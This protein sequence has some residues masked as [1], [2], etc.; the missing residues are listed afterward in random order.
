[1]IALAGAF[2]AGVVLGFFFASLG[3]LVRER[4]HR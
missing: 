4:G 1:V 3:M 2:V